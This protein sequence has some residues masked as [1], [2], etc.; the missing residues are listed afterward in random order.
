MTFTGATINFG[1]ASV[2]GVI[3]GAFVSAIL[4]GNFH[5][6]AFADVQDMLR[7][8]SGGA[9][10]GIGGVMALGCTIGQGL[11]GISTLALGSV[12]AILAIIAGGVAGL[13]YIEWRL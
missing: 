8:I 10:M 1:I 11:T 5:L 2:G 3:L 6:A 7:N 4:R 9:L 12:L 13:K